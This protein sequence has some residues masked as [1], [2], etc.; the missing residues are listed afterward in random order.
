MN[1]LQIIKW[2]N[3]NSQYKRS[4][5]GEGN[6]EVSEGVKWDDLWKVYK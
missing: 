1:R 4:V 3:H 2:K 6:E 5:V